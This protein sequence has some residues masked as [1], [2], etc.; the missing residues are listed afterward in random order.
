[1][2]LIPGTE[3]VNRKRPN[4]IVKESAEVLT[5][6]GREFAARRIAAVMSALIIA[7]TVYQIGRAH[8]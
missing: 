6:N 3:A 1:M 7:Y 8:V 2:P 5:G 4:A